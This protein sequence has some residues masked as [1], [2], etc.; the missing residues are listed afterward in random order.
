MAGTFLTRA[1]LLR[2]IAYGESDRVVTLLGQATGRVSA[3]ARGARKSQ[4]RFGGGLGMGALGEAS[5][6]ERGGADLMSLESFDVAEPRSGLGGDVGRTAHAAYALELVEKL[7]APRQPEPA[8]FDWL[9]EFLSRLEAGAASAERLRV[10][11]LGLLRHLGLGPQLK[12]C[13]ACGRA[14]LGDETLRWHPE[15]GGV[16]CCIRNGSLL[17]PAVRHALARLSETSMADLV[18]LDRDI[19]AGCRQAIFE[20]FRGHLSG[21]LKSLE[22]IAKMGKVGGI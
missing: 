6:R 12:T 11:E 16:I 2:S 7:C 10:F 8:V 13:V 1:I 21:P 4:K 17:T 19:N 14:D 3:L 22:F 9:D 18:P 15:R 5:L 20:L